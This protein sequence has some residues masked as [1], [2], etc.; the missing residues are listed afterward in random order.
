M[1]EVIKKEYEIIRTRFHSRV[2]DITEDVAD[3]LPEGFS[4]NIRWNIG[5]VLVVTEKFLF[6]DKGNLPAQYYEFFAPGTKPSDWTGEVPTIAVLVQQLEKQYNRIK[7]LPNETF[8]EKL[9]EPLLGNHTV[10]ELA[11]FSCFHESYHLGQIM[12]MKRTIEA[13]LAKSN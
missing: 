9:A 11:V 10:G 6:A 3:I 7:D 2:A 12:A 8:N 1:G 4:N 5:H 13:S